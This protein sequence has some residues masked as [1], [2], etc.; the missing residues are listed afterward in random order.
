M[1]AAAP[2][3]P[4]HD[5]LGDG[6]HLADDSGDD[7]EL[8]ALALLALPEAPVAPPAVVDALAGGASDPIGALEPLGNRCHECQLRP[9][10]SR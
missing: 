8:A 2:A 6:G 1:A 5:G 10:Y 4:D 3:V 9:H 7:D